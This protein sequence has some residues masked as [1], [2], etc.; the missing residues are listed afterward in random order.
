MLH[1][2]PYPPTPLCPNT[3]ACICIMATYIML[4]INT[5]RSL[6]L[7]H[8]SALFYVFSA[9]CRRNIKR[10]FQLLLLMPLIII[11]VAKNSVPGHQHG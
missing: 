2:C 3:D 5:G 11:M 10:C 6:L 1:L 8:F 4:A 7:F 9:T